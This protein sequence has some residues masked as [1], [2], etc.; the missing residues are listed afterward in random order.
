MNPQL[1]EQV[2]IVSG[3][4]F[5]GAFFGGADAVPADVDVLVPVPEPREREDM[6]ELLWSELKD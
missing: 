5:F 2:R 4:S 6:N 1:L 3:V